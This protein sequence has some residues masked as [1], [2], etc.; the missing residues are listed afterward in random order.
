MTGLRS[1]YGR[2]G[3]ICAHFGWTWG[4]LHHGVPWAVV[5][6]MMIDA[7]SYEYKRDDGTDDGETF[8]EEDAE[9]FFSGLTNTHGYEYKRRGT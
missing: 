3:S 8:T 4:Y 9:A 6:R 2:R 7:P 1:P 5:Q